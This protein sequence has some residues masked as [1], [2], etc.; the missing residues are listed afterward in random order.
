MHRHVLPV[1]SDKI[2][3]Q[4]NNVHTVVIKCFVAE[5]RQKVR[6]QFDAVNLSSHRARLFPWIDAYMEKVDICGSST[7]DLT[8][9]ANFEMDFVAVDPG[10][11]RH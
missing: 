11:K 4:L 2:F 10:P 1:P 5:W 3:F 6:R 8:N 7:L 9:K